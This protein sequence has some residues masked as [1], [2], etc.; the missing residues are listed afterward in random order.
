MNCKEIAENYAQA[1]ELIRIQEGGKTRLFIIIC[2]LGFALIME[3]AY[4]IY[5]RK[6]DSEFEIEQTT[7][8]IQDSS[9]HDAYIDGS[10][11]II[12]G[13]TS[14]ENNQIKR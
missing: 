5:D 4:I 2:I 7:E 1:T 13:A 3:S 10:G 8:V 14:K 9:G 11:V 12:N 6:L